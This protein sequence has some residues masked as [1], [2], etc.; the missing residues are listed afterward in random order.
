M[1]AIVV[2][3]VEAK[4]LDYR[5]ITSKARYFFPKKDFAGLNALKS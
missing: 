4:M 1:D 3:V 5:C 2:V